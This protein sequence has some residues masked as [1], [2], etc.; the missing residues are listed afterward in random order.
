MK[1]KRI[2]VVQIDVLGGV[3]NVVAI[4]KG[5]R[6]IIRDYDNEECGEKPCIATYEGSTKEK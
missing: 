5:V 3:A 4:P 6:V 2:K 1:K